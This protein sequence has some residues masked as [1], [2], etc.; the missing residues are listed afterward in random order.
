MKE[1]NIYENV[2]DIQEEMDSEWQFLYL[3]RQYMQ[4]MKENVVFIYPTSQ[5][6]R[7]VKRKRKY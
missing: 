1:I 7:S 5:I 2:E 4:I 6:Y 3:V